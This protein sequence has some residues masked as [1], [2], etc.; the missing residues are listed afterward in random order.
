MASH[1]LDFKALIKI[2]KMQTKVQKTKTKAG[3]F[4]IEFPHFLTP[5]GSFA[6]ARPD[7]ASV[8][9]LQDRKGQKGSYC[10]SNKEIAFVQLFL[11]K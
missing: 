6:Y 1:F 5:M 7:L 8:S 10:K 4:E 2:S 3:K 11:P 9:K